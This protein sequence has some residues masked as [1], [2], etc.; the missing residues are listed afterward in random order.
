VDKKKKSI[1]KLFGYKH[2]INKEKWQETFFLKIF[3]VQLKRTAFE[4][5][6]YFIVIFDQFNAPL[7]NK[8]I[9]F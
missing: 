7:L 6:V 4:I 3:D 2:I 5:E 8:S 1:K 9:T